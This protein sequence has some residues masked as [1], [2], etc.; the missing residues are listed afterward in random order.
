VE[1]LCIVDVPI[2]RGSAWWRRSKPFHPHFEQRLDRL[3]RHGATGKTIPP[4]GGVDWI[5][6][7]FGD[8]ALMITR[9]ASTSSTIS[10][11]GEMVPRDVLSAAGAGFVIAS[12][13]VS[14]SSTPLC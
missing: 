4:A 14:K 1:R 7:G 10:A 5:D 6:T 12:V 9:V 2:W 8:P 11:R 3:R 13:L